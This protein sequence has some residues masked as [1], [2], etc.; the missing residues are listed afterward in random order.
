VRR[1]L[2]AAPL[3]YLAVAV[4]TGPRVSPVVFA[5]DRGQMWFVVAR[6]SLKARAIARDGRVGG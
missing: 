3:L 2:D 4:R 6:N 5:A 1:V